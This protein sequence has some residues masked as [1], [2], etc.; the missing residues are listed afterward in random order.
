MNPGSAP[1]LHQIRI[2]DI[3]VR[4]SMT[5]QLINIRG[6]NNW[7]FQV[8]VLRGRKRCGEGLTVFEDINAMI[9]R[10]TEIEMMN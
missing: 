4:D 3:P 7:D 6:L 9:F 1:I 2:L 8:L 5:P 10:Q